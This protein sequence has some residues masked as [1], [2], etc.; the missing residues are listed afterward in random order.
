MHLI[1]DLETTGLDPKRCQILEI[2]AILLNDQLDPIDAF[3]RLIYHDLNALYWET[4]AYELHEK[5]G[6]LA[7]LD[8][9][10]K[11]KVSLDQAQS[12]LIALYA[13]HGATERAILVGNNPQFD[14][15]FV[16]AQAAGLSALLDFR[17]LDVSSLRYVA[18]AVAGVSHKR[19]KSAFRPNGAQ[20]R[21]LSDCEACLTELRTCAQMMRAG[22]DLL[23]GA[24]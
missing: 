5:N 20:H 9:P 3:S 8:D 19:L 4:T 15:G 1:L 16:D 18:A 10:S 22:R 7:D 2:G 24:L 13:R 11:P 14:R 6:L 23:K 21:A 17:N 12:E